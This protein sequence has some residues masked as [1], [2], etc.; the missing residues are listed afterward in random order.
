MIEVIKVKEFK[1]LKLK[2]KKKSLTDVAF[3]KIKELILNEEI[4]SGEMVSENQLAEYLNMSRTPIREAIRRLEA[5]GILISRQGYGTIVKMLTLKDIE[6]VFEV[7]EAM[8]L[9]A[10]ETAIHNISNQEIQEVKDDFLNLLERHHR[11]EIIEKEEFTAIDGQ[12]HDLIV[13]KSDNEYVK[14]LMERI[15]FNVGRYR[16]MSYKVSLDLEESTN[17]H[18]KLLKDM[19]ERNVEVFKEHLKEHLL[20]SLNIIKKHARL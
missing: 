11:G 20:W 7:R 4:E 10:S 9:I 17:Q 12:I 15:D 8:E 2:A 6:D 18:L 3:E 13:K 16:A 14:M 5:D 19:E 1:D